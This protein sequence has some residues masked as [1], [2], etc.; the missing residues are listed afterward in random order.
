MDTRCGL[1]CS[2]CGYRERMDCGGCVAS[3]GHP[4]HGECPIAVCCQAKGLAHC[5]KCEI[6]PCG[7]LRQYSEDPVHGDDPPGARI[8]VCRKWADAD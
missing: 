3:Q 6:F 5:G 1:C 4:F 8:A 7:L 2:T